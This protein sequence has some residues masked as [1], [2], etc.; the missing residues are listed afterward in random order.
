MPVYPYQA[1]GY[2]FGHASPYGG[3]GH[4]YNPCPPG[5][6]PAFGGCVV[7]G[8]T[9]IGQPA[10]PGMMYPAPMLQGYA[11]W[12]GKATACPPGWH[13]DAYLEQCVKNG[14]PHVGQYAYGWP[15]PQLGAPS[16]PW[17]GPP[18][19]CPP[20]MVAYVGHDGQVYCVPAQAAA[21][22]TRASVYPGPGHHYR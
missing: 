17:Y 10:P 12:P 18:P 21:M 6:L 11:A 16:G 1:P 4:W 8:Q 3:D 15:H 22:W 14:P 2:T 9:P 19:H 13:H 5:Q 20:G 7:P